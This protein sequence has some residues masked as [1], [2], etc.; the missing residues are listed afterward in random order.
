[1]S[2]KTPGTV[3]DLGGVDAAG[4]LGLTDAE[5]DR[6]TAG[7]LQL[8][9]PASGT[10]TVSGA[11]TRT[12]ATNLVLT[13]ASGNNITFDADATPGSLDAGGGDVTL[14]TSGTGAILSGGATVDIAAANLSLAA[15]SGGIGASGNPLAMSAATLTTDTNDAAD[16]PQFLSAADALTIAADGFNAGTSTITLAD[17]TFVLGGSERVADASLLDVATDATFRLANFNETIAGLRGAGI[18][19]NESGTAGTGTLTINV[20]RLIRVDFTS[21]VTYVQAAPVLGLTPAIGDLVSGY[22]VYDPAAPDTD[23]GDPSR[24]IYR[25]G[26]A[27]ISIGG[28][29]IASTAAPT[30]VVF[31]IGPPGNDLFGIAAG[32]SQNGSPLLVDGIP[33]NDSYLA[34]SFTQPVGALSSD[35]LPNPFPVGMLEISQFNVV[36]DKP[37]FIDGVLIYDDLQSIAATYVGAEPE[38]SGTLRNGDGMDADGTLVVTKTGIGTQSFSGQNT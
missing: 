12:A 24:G 16:G 30:A 22:F 32:V 19:E 26:E 37:G 5:L 9:G 7:T 18:V 27:S 34:L 23:P 28:S 29:T 3:I 1:V 21:K 6:I 31:D 4:T 38:F 36:Q 8:G 15:G 33:S 13:T 2:P 17:G 35:R 11:I 25:T 10:I 14:A 20:P